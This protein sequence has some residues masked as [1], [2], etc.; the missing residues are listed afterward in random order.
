MAVKGIDIEGRM[1]EHSTPLLFFPKVREKGQEDKGP[2]SWSTVLGRNG[3]GK[4]TISTAL[5]NYT[6]PRI[7]EAENY[8]ESLPSDD[9]QV[10]LNPDD[11]VEKEHIYVFNEDFIR[12]KLRFDSDELGA[13][14][15]LKEQED[16]KK[17]INNA[18][19]EKD[20]AKKKAYCLRY[21][22][23]RSDNKPES[24]EY[25]DVIDLKKAV[26]TKADKIVNNFRGD[27]NWAGICKEISNQ[28][29]NRSVSLSSISDMYSKYY[30]Q[31]INEDELGTK[32]KEF[33]TRLEN[34][35]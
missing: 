19:H 3:A 22:T 24:P 17:E 23:G 28:R 5:W 11:G 16:L 31:L 1:Y 32:Q 26:T 8:D 10:T 9:L 34:F 18:K 27:D 12:N 6:H 29:K 20:K 25:K 15:M 35:L 33:H 14:L 2:C 7:E 21:E 4:S 30:S 13:I